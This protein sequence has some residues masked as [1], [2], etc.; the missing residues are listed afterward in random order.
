M[1]HEQHTKHCF[2]P[3]NTTTT[4]ALKTTKGPT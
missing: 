2:N 4:H 3:Y 1:T